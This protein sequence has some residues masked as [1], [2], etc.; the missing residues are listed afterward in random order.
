M[1]ELDGK[2]KLKTLSN[3]LVECSDYDEDF[4]TFA[5]ENEDYVRIALYAKNVVDGYAIATEKLLAKCDEA[6]A[7]LQRFLDDADGDDE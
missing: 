1:S 3:L 4:W 5:V 6:T 2:E 7:I